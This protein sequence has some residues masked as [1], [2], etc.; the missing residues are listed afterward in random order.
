MWNMEELKKTLWKKERGKR[1]KWKVRE[2]K[3]GRE[4]GGGGGIGY[5]NGRRERWGRVWKWKGRRWGR[6]RG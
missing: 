1:G 2:A 6:R 5:V 3:E 4:N